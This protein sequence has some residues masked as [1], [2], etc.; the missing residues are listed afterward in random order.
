[1]NKF[2]YYPRPSL[3]GKLLQG[4]DRRA[5][6]ASAKLW[7]DGQN[8]RTGLI[9]MMPAA[10]TVRT[11]GNATDVANVRGMDGSAAARADLALQVSARARRTRPAV[12]ADAAY[13][14]VR[15]LPE[16][17]LATIQSGH[18]ESWEAEARANQLLKE[19]MKKLAGRERAHGYPSHSQ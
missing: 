1:M 10:P 15:T 6:L 8:L 7:E 5:P 14:I 9:K 17:W 16:E 3:P 13:R 2:N 18:R 12:L 4:R 11:A 19:A